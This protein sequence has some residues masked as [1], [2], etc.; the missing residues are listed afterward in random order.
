MSAIPQIAALSPEGLASAIA[1]ALGHGRETHSGNTWRTYCPAHPD[2]GSPGLE[3]TIKGGKVLAHCW[4][5]GCPQSA[6]VDELKS[7]GL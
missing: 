4:N 1:Q 2:E 3:L 7:R 5:N 6:V